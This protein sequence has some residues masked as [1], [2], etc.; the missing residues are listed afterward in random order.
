MLQRR[1]HYIIIYLLKIFKEPGPNMGLTVNS[2]QRQGRLCYI[3][4]ADATTHL[5]TTVHNY[6]NGAV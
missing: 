4:R 2:H 1:K 6:L 3:R 5:R